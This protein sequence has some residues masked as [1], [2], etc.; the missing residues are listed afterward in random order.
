MLWVEWQWLVDPNSLFAGIGTGALMDDDRNKL[1]TPSMEWHGER[2]V[3]FLHSLFVLIECTAAHFATFPLTAR[4]F[5]FPFYYFA[6]CSAVAFMMRSCSR[7]S[8]SMY[9]HIYEWR[10][11][12]ANEYAK[13]FIV[14]RSIW[15]WR[16][17]IVSVNDGNC[18]KCQICFIRI[19]PT[20]SSPS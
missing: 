19:Y 10:M 8:S 13:P 7:L 4:P 3:N 11:T 1:T 5:L 20:A 18:I 6:K 9:P 17:C 14:Q 16:R 15:L 2:E 12:Y